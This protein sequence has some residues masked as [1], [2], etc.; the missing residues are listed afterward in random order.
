MLALVSLL[1]F[2]IIRLLPGD[3]VTLM[4]SEQGYA[5]EKAKLEEMLGLD[6][7]F[8]RQYISYIGRVLQGDLGVSSDARSPSSTR[9]CG[10]CP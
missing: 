4:M 9:S 10:A 1:V 2:S 7:P 3:I 6:Q 8:Y 5:S